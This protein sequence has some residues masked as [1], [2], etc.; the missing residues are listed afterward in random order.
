[1]LSELSSYLE[2]NAGLPF[3]PNKPRLKAS[4]KKIIIIIIIFPYK[5]GPTLL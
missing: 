3:K 4:L 5:K 2:C 1:M